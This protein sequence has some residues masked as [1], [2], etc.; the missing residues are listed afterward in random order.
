ML[1]VFQHVQT[2][3]HS[4]CVGLLP[5]IIKWAKMAEEEERDDIKK[6]SMTSL[7]LFSVKP[8]Q[9]IAKYLPQ[10]MELFVI[11]S[12]MSDLFSKFH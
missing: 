3:T 6:I 8:P 11:P 4:G 7:Q 10:I 2:A 12:N 9:E 1:C 5:D